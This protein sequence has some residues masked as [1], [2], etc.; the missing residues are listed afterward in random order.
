MTLTEAKEHLRLSAASTEDR[1]L[2]FLLGRLIGEIEIAASFKAAGMH[3]EAK[4]TARYVS[5]RVSELRRDPRVQPETQAA[6]DVV[7]NFADE[8]LRLP[9][10]DLDR[11]RSAA[12]KTM[13]SQRRPGPEK[14]R[15]GSRVR[16]APLEALREFMKTWHYHHALVPEQLR[17]A[18]MVTRIASVEYYHGGD[19]VY[20]LDDTGNFAWLEPCLK[21]VEP[22]D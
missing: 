11:E 6:L 18:D 1:S 8:V 20:T 7:G 16:I 9:E 3:N 2:Q 17:Y 14:Y 21:G 13:M 5:A 19:V 22:A 10:T 12:A 4:Y 15:F